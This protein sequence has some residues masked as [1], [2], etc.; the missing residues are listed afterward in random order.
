MGNTVSGVRGWGATATALTACT[1][2]YGRKCGSRPEARVD[3]VRGHRDVPLRQRQAEGQDEGGG[4][5]GGREHAMP[6]GGGAFHQA[7]VEH[8]ADGQ[9]DG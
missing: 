2:T 1:D 8:Q 9:E 3:H 6:Q 7:P 4:E 5:Q